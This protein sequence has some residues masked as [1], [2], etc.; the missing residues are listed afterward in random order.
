MA[1]PPPPPCTPKFEESWKAVI[2]FAKTVLSIASA[3]LAAVASLLLVGSY[4]LQGYGWASPVLLIGSMLLCLYGLGGAIVALRRGVHNNRAL[5]YCNVSVVLLVAAIVAAPFTINVEPKVVSIDQ[6]LAKVE[7][8][9]RQW[10]A[11]LAARNCRKIERSGDDVVLTYDA[12][13][14]TV[15]VA[16]STTRKEIVQIR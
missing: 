13:G 7:T 5:L 12:G 9:T 2:D 6:I 3:L 11:E 4:E 1:T 10:P 14:K 15:Q 8:T 16:Y